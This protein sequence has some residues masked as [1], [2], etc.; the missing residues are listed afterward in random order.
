MIGFVISPNDPVRAVATFDE[1]RAAPTDTLRKLAQLMTDTEHDA[2][3]IQRHDGQR[4]I[5]TERDIVRALG[6]GG[7]ADT[8]WATDV[9]SRDM[10]QVTADESIRNVVQQMVDHGV[11]HMVVTD[12]D[13]VGIVSYRDV[14]PPLLATLS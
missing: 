1:V 2:L 11:R 5:V 6:G 7:R 8:E 9:M 3:I 4:A 14:V 13:L 10:Y 12:G